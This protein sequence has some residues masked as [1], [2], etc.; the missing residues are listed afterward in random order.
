MPNIDEDTLEE[1]FVV[2]GDL[3]WK[4]RV[5]F[6]W[7]KTKQGMGLLSRVSVDIWKGMVVGII[8][9]NIGEIRHS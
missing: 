1:V 4:I 5:N 6:F 3:H 9:L 2:D 8:G 7:R